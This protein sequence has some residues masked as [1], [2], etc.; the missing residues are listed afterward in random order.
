LKGT[1]TPK[2]TIQQKSRLATS[3]CPQL[4]FFQVIE[5]ASVKTILLEPRLIN[6]IEGEDRRAP[7]MAYLCYYYKSD[8]TNEQIRMQQ[9]VRAYH[10]VDN[11]LHKASVSGPLL[12]CL[13]NV[14]GRKFSR[15]SMQESMEATSAL[16]R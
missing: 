12:W 9:R 1:K 5:D 3:R 16:V 11:N 10:I 8:S 2:L 13:S 15:K 14:E 6:I 4:Y 7:I